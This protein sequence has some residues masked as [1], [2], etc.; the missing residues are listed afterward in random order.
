MY[1]LPGEEL[2]IT[3]G[4][5]AEAGV[6]R[7]AKLE[8]HETYLMKLTPHGMSR[9]QTATQL[10]DPQLVC[11]PRRDVALEDST[12][13][14]LLEQLSAIG[15]RWCRL[16]SKPA[17]RNALVFEEGSALVWYSNTNCPHRLYLLCLLKAE[18][19]RR[20][21]ILAIP[22]HAVAP[23]QVYGGILKGKPPRRGPALEMLPDADEAPVPEVAAILDEAA[24][25]A[26]DGY[27]PDGP[28]AALEGEVMRL[29]GEILRIME[30]EEEEDDKESLAEAEGVSEGAGSELDGSADAPDDGD[31][32]VPPPPPLP[33]PPAAPPAPPVVHRPGDVHRWGCFRLSIL[34][35]L[36]SR[37]H[38]AIEAACP[39]HKKN[40]KT[41]CKKLVRMRD[42]TPAEA[43]KVF[44]ALKLWCVAGVDMNRQRHHMG[45]HV[46]VDDPPIA[47]AIEAMIITEGP[48]APPTPDDALDVEGAG[49]GAADR[50]RGAG[51]GRARGGGGRGAGRGRGR[52]GGEPGGA[53][54]EA[55]ASGSDSS[56]DSAGP[57]GSSS[58]GSGSSSESSGGDSTS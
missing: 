33:P 48:L 49:A 38:G 32:D 24:G 34:R 28:D 58:S 46:D 15:W 41:D 8:G 39:W 10:L 19:L 5:L 11:V 4:R 31:D 30:E 17:D 16:P 2:D 57:A 22:H 37:P 47:E 3:W 43:D 21:G 45:I 25:D 54:G 42:G 40:S 9:L 56:H 27:D 13:F 20:R 23:K 26:G 12:A 6:V 55:S 14:E 1:V 52:A 51:R 29:E 36:A 7:I 50:G 44:R 18:E 53:V 35:P